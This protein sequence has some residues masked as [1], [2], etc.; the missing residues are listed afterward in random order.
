M[1]HTGERKAPPVRVKIPKEDRPMRFPKE[2]RIFND[3][4]GRRMKDVPPEEIDAHKRAMTNRM[5]QSHRDYLKSLSPEALAE[6]KSNQKW[7]REERQ[8]VKEEKARVKAQQVLNE[9]E[10]AIL[11]YMVKSGTFYYH[12]GEAD[13]MHPEIIKAMTYVMEN[14]KHT[15]YNSYIWNYQGEG[16]NDMSVSLFGKLWRHSDFETIY[17]VPLDGTWIFYGYDSGERGSGSFHRMSAHPAGKPPYV[18]KVNPGGL[19][20]ITAP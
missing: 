18:P 19:P 9:R 4:S 20:Q 8:R 12:H 10:L 14:K 16:N 7:A 1:V 2:E 3:G 6:Y 5:S 11:G 17:D 13:N 15:E